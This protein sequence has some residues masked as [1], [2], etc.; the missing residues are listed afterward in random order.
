MIE[1]VQYKEEEA[2]NAKEALERAEAESRDRYVDLLTAAQEFGSWADGLKMA[3]EKQ[4]GEVED[5]IV[6]LIA[7]NQF[8]MNRLTPLLQLEK[9]TLDGQGVT[10][11]LLAEAEADVLQAEGFEYIK[12][13]WG[14]TAA[15][16]EEHLALPI[17]KFKMWFEAAGESSV[18]MENA[19]LKERIA[20]LEDQLVAVQQELKSH[21][22]LKDLPK[23]AEEVQKEAEK[24]EVLKEGKDAV[25]EQQEGPTITGGN[26]EAAEEKVAED[27]E[28]NTADQGILGPR[29]AFGS[30]HQAVPGV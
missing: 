24:S 16:F 1:A 4:F 2:R 29:S 28:G 25:S 8:L 23:Q 20:K 12:E 26:A 3:T 27:K 22:L 9:A 7:D 11:V 18:R 15:M 17:D 19:G 14:Q 5:R 13:L 21:M 6:Q 30:S 10:G